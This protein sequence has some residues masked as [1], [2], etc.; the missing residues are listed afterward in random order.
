MAKALSLNAGLVR[1]FGLTDAVN[2]LTDIA[3]GNAAA[4][5]T[6][7][8]NIPANSLT[9]GAQFV[10]RLSGNLVK[11]LATNSN[12]VVGVRVAASSF[13]MATVALG[14]T[15]FTGNGRGFVT[16]GTITFRAV[17]VAG[18]AQAELD[19]AV[20]GVAAV[21]SNQVTPTTMN[22][23]VPLNLLLAVSTSNATTTGSIR[24][25]MIQRVA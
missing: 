12:V 11:T 1:E 20:S 22:T 3:F 25:C 15:T 14:T 18:S 9:A 8:F 13:L 5:L 6:P 23:T 19:V 4:G 7:A 24:S 21:M 17:G 10:F 2:T 16:T